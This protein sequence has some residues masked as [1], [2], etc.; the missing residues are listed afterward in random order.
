[1][2]WEKPFSTTISDRLKRK[3]RTNI[4]CISDPPSIY[5]QLNNIKTTRN[6]WETQLPQISPCSSDNILLLRPPHRRTRPIQPLPPSCFHLDKTKHPV[7][8]S[9]NIN[10]P[11]LP[12]VISAKNNHTHFPHSPTSQTFTACT[13]TQMR[14]SQLLETQCHNNSQNK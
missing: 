8:K 9:N 5:N 7:L 12:C 1:M 13:Q 11:P 14:V 2:K 4:S 3:C 6:R 10:L